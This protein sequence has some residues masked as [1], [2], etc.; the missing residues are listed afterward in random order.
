MRDILIADRGRDKDFLYPPPPRKENDEN[1]VG[2][3]VLG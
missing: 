3:V 1:D 2:L